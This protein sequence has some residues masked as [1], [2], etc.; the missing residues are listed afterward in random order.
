[1]QRQ[2]VFIG[3]RGVAGAVIAKRVARH[4]EQILTVAQRRPVVAT[5]P[6]EFTG[7]E[8]MIETRNET[9][10]LAV[11]LRGV[12]P[13][14]VRRGQ[15]SPLERGRGRT[16]DPARLHLLDLR[17]QVVGPGGVTLAEGGHGFVELLPRQPGGQ[18]P[19]RRPAFGQIVSA[20][21][22]RPLR[23]GEL[24]LHLI[25]FAPQEFL[26]GRIRPFQI[27]PDL[28]LTPFKRRLVLLDRIPD[29]DVAAD[30]ASDIG[31]AGISLLSRT[32]RGPFRRP[33]SHRLE[34]R[35]RR[36]RRPRTRPAARSPRPVAVC[37]PGT[38]F[39]PI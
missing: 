36:S 2:R 9:R 6:R 34:R 38:D 13:A 1:M 33:S 25:E 24:P 32:H 16:R 20:R 19:Q 21:R 22:E 27:R 18:V 31:A 8:E 28:D 10:R 12:A 11:V 37:D 39:E 29:G 30:V 23:I 17:E 3:G 7:R 35:R 4:F 26:L 14:N 15:L 5:A